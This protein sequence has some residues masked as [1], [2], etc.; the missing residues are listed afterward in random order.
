M[1]PGK[2]RRRIIEDDDITFE[3]SNAEKKQKDEEKKEGEKEPEFKKKLRPPVAGLKK[4]ASMS[5][6]VQKAPIPQKKEGLNEALNTSRMKTN[7]F[8][9]KEKQEEEVIVTPKGKEKVSL[10]K[11]IEGISEDLLK[12]VKS[13][14][15]ITKPGE[16][17]PMISEEEHKELVRKKYIEGTEVK[18]HITLTLFRAKDKKKLLP[19]REKK[20]HT[21]QGAKFLS[22]EKEIPIWTPPSSVGF[23]LG[24]IKKGLRVWLAN[25]PKKENFVENKRIKSQMKDFDEEV[26]DS[27]LTVF[28]RENHVVLAAGY[29]LRGP[30]I[31]ERYKGSREKAPVA[32]WSPPSSPREI[33]NKHIENSINAEI[34]NIER[35]IVKF[36]EEINAVDTRGAVSSISSSRPR[37]LSQGAGLSTSGASSSVQHASTSIS[38]PRPLSQ[39][40]GLSTSGASSSVQH[41]STYEVLILKNA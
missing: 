1:L 11:E 41:T 5:S 14:R 36:I 32:V 39:E 10:S 30:K 37:P 12:S 25:E 26:P 3:Q 16:V 33:N 34:P 19:E 15:G 18:D 40:A 13:I 20:E 27:H 9:K 17:S 28:A 31:S 8:T 22:N 29:S 23:V 24:G 38:R 6:G 21:V 35:G 2:K 4:Q 7:L